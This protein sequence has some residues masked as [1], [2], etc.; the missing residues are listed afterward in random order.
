MKRGG[1]VIYAGPLGQ[2]SNHL[3]EYFE[4]STTTSRHCLCDCIE[5]QTQIHGDVYRLICELLQSISGVPKIK[6]GSN[7]ATW[8]LEITS[9]AVEAQLDVDFAEI[10]AKSDLYWYGE[11]KNPSLICSFA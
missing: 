2:N 1:R 7:P 3:V 5:N 11:R 8:M 4:V 10:F 6:E 9:S